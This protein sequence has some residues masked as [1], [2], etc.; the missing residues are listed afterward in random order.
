MMPSL[1]VGRRRDRMP[2]VGADVVVLGRASV[3][4]RRVRE[5]VRPLPEALPDRPNAAPQP[6]HGY[7]RW[8]LVWMNDSWLAL[9]AMP[10]FSQPKKPIRA[11]SERS[12]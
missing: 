8:L 9:S 5:P 11:T 1:V 4:L 7:T 6:G 10:H 12:G 2:L 3:R